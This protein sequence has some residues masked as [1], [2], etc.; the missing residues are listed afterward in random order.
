MT[1]KQKQNKKIDQKTKTKN[2]D[3]KRDQRQELNNKK[4]GISGC[5]RRGRSYC[6]LLHTCCTTRI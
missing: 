5:W 6:F 4:P 2:T 3:N 1:K